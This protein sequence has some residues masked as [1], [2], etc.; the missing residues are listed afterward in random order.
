MSTSGAEL[1]TDLPELRFDAGLPGFP[2][3]RRFVLVRL[4]DADSPFSV[5]RSLDD[6]G[7]EFVV[8][9]P[10]LFFPDYEPEIDD[11][12]VNRLEL[13]SPDDALLLVVVTVADQPADSTA[14]LLGPLVVNRQTRAAA[15]AVLDPT[16]YSTRELLLTG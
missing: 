15:Q 5:L 13:R 11:E 4:G 16:R 8:V 1:A 6:A 3:A 7:L 10:G 14:N 9:P 12:V 2:Q